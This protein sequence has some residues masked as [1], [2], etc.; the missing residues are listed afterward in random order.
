MT[1]HQKTSNPHGPNR[2]ERTYLT[3]AEVLAEIGVKPS[4]FWRWRT[5]GRGPKAHRLPNGQL[6]FARQEIDRWWESLEQ[7]A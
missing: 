1:K 6:R 7:E 4:T 3:T 2:A 5:T